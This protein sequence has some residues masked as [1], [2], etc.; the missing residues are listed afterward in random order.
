[1]TKSIYKYLITVF[2]LLLLFVPISYFLI[3]PNYNILIG[4]FKRVD[5]KRYTYDICFSLLTTVAPTKEQILGTSQ[6]LVEDVSI[7]EYL[8]EV[9]D[10][11]PILEKLNTKLEI[12]SIG[13]KGNIFQG[14]DS[15]TLEKGFWHFPLSKYPGQKGNVVVISHRYLHIPPAKN[16]FFN[17]DKVRK[18]DS[19]FFTQEGNSY[20]YIVSEVKIVEKNDISVIQDSSDY[21]VTLITCTPL[22]TSHQR[23]VVIGKLDKLYQKT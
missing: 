18:G 14:S 9:E 3:L 21:R 23:L 17:L 19:L 5:L 4:T 20:N 6:I 16:T 8:G 13:V 7:E 15:N 10:I 2:L 22:W 11:D 12:E 1:M